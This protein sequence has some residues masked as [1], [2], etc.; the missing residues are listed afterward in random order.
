MSKKTVLLA[1]RERIFAE[2]VKASL[3][4][5]YDVL[6]IAADGKAL[7]SANETLKPDVVIVDF[8]IPF[9]NDLQTLTKLRNQPNRPKIIVLTMAADA[10]SVSEAL[11]AGVAGY[12]LKTS[13]PSELLTAVEKVL[14]GGT[15]ITPRLPFAAAKISRLT[16]DKELRSLSHREREVLQ[17][18]AKG[19][20]SRE[21]AT[22]LNISTKTVES[23]RSNISRHLDIHSIAELTRYAIERGIL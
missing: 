20:T 11:R 6:G 12:L 16:A 17:L 23:H 14:R 15:Y 7:L 1:H 13:P 9:L 18:I 3:A 8:V 19:H 22:A 10:A 5:K 21:I 2:G 4:G